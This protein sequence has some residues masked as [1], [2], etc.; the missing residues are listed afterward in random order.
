MAEEARLHFRN[1]SRNRA[2][3]CPPRWQESGFAHARRQKGTWRGTGG[4][5]HETAWIE[6]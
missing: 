3:C 2:H 4:E 6:V 1:E 5:N